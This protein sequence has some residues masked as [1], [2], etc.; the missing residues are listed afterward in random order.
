MIDEKFTLGEA[1][2]LL[3]FK[4]A[5]AKWSQIGLSRYLPVL[6]QNFL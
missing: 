1:R 5:W 6:G 3:L 4:Y 2:A